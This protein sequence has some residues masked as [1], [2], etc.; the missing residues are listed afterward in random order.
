MRLAMIN[1]KFEDKISVFDRGLAYGDGFFET[2]AW[3]YVEEKKKM[4]S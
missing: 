4:Q 1:G 3:R 2:T